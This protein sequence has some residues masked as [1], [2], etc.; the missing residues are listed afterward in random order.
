MQST[1]KYKATLDKSISFLLSKLPFD[2]SKRIND[3]CKENDIYILNEIRIHAK[4]NVL[5]IKSC[6]TIRTD[7]YI[8]NAEI[9]EIVASLCD[10][11]IYAHIDTIKQGYISVG[12][13]IRAGICGRAILENGTITA[14]RDISSIN[15]RLPNRISFAGEYLFNLIKDNHYN[16]SVLIYS[17]P[18]VGKTTILRDLIYRL[19]KSNDLITH[20]VID[21]RD[22]IASF[23]DEDIQADVYLSYPKG[24]GIELATKSMAPRLIICDEISSYEEAVAINNSANCGVKLIAT[25][26]SGTIEELKSKEILKG[27]FINKV[28]D[29][30]LK[31]SRDTKTN[32][33]L[34]EL[35]KLWKL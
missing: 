6:N 31:V 15:I 3:F 34:Y 23:L 10:N 8:D 17:L 4:T 26:H 7:I 19:S 25:T 16:I 1:I 28:F 32:K 22:E 21:T 9:E 30:A 11:S 12:N 18:G 35:D 27:L 5:L 33:Y 13:G 29:Y 24:L 2:L 20:A 14:I